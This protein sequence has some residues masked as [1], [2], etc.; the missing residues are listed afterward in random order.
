MAEFLSIILVGLVVNTIIAAIVSSHAKENGQGGYFWLVFFLGIIGV[1]LYVA[2]V[3][4][5]DSSGSQSKKSDW[6]STQAETGYG[7]KQIEEADPAVSAVYDKIKTVGEAKPKYFIDRIYPAYPSGFDSSQKWWDN[8]I[9]PELELFQD[10]ESPT[11]NRDTWVHNYSRK[12]HSSSTSQNDE[13]S[14]ESWMTTPDTEFMHREIDNRDRGLYVEVTDGE[15]EGNF[16]VNDGK[17]SMKS[18]KVET[19][20]GEEWTSKAVSYLRE[21]Y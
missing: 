11:D 3:A 20:N 18:Y 14:S 13:S 8:Y 6:K 1:L 21:S 4:G 9:A 2:D 5:S 16:F 7:D 19:E 10:V 12:R 17:V 15:K